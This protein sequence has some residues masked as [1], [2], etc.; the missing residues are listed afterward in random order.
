MF[1][2][3]L[4]KIKT[5]D[6]TKNNSVIPCVSYPKKTSNK[7]AVYFKISIFLFA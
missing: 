6:F 1:I 7:L 4:F 2:I 5:Q 3:I